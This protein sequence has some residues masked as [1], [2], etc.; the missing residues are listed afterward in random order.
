[1]STTSVTE[2]TIPTTGT[3]SPVVVG[4]DSSAA[5]QAALTWAIQEADSLSRPLHVVHAHTIQE[6]WP[7]HY[8]VLT[9]PPPHED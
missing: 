4:V 9:A 3:G 5:G 2:Q 7:G 8:G 1:M 6:Q